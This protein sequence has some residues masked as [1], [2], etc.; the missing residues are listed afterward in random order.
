MAKIRIYNGQRVHDRW[1]ETKAGQR[2]GNMVVVLAGPKPRTR[3]VVPFS[4][5]KAKTRV[6]NG[7]LPQKKE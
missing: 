2:T 4:E 5:W 7:L 6:V 3:L 1:P